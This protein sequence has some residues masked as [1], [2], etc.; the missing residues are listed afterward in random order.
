MQFKQEY[1]SLDCLKTRNLYLYIFAVSRAYFTTKFAGG[2]YINSWRFRWR[3]VHVDRV[4]FKLLVMFR[5]PLHRSGL[6]KGLPLR[7]MLLCPMN[8]WRF[9]WL[10]IY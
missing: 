2:S 5:E 8:H 1:Y 9:R 10:L 3:A 4:T 7:E 6:F